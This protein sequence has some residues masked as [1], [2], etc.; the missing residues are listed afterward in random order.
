MDP[1]QYEELK[2][3]PGNETYFLEFMAGGEVVCREGTG[4][5]LSGTYTFVGVS[6]IRIGW[7]VVPTSAAGQFFGQ[8]GLY[9]V[10]ISGATM[11][12]TREDGVEASYRRVS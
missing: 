3:L 4:P 2:K 1:R 6:S 8:L 11:Y 10:Q 5:V 7:G 9:G 12:L